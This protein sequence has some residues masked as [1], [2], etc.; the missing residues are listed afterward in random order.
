MKGDF[1]AWPFDPNPDY[2]GV[3]HQQG[4]VLIDS[5]LNEQNVILTQSIRAVIADIIGW[6]GTPELASSSPGAGGFAVSLDGDRVLIGP[7]HYYVDGILCRARGTNRLEISALRSR[8]DPPT[9]LALLVYLDLWE[10]AVTAAEDPDL[11]LPALGVDT[12]A[13]RMLEYRI[14]TAEVDRSSVPFGGRGAFEAAVGLHPSA[15]AITIQPRIRE[16]EAVPGEIPSPGGYESLENHLYRLEIHDRQASDDGESI[17]FKWSR[18]NGSVVAS[19]DEIAGTTVRVPDDS[20]VAKRSLE[21]G[22]GDWVELIDDSD[23]STVAELYRVVKADADG[24]VEVDRAPTIRRTN[25]PLL[26]VWNGVS[27]VTLSAKGESHESPW[28]DIEHG[29][30]VHFDRSGTQPGD[31]WVLGLSPGLRHPLRWPVDDRGAKPL[32]PF[33]VEHHRAPLAVIAG[34]EVIDLRRFFMPLTEQR[35]RKPR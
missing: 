32:P 24:T 26:R 25:H 6:H 13:R 9:K 14:R 7:G 18:D 3:M 2:T 30:Q 17:V 1:A 35:S 4:R 12:S 15:E 27:T 31:Y 19:V 28:S 20:E 23:T 11:V 16:P 8:S 22:S 29:L 5:D 33:G 10:R 21:I 34:D